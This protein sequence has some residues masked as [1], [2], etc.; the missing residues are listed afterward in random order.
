MYTLLV[1]KV[2]LAS[3]MLP[4]VAGLL[5]LPCRQRPNIRFN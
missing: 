3:P 5:D 2:A 4:A 1:L